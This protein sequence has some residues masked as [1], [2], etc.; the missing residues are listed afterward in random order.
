M[1]SFLLKLMNII[2][3][4]KES[5]I[6]FAI[7]DTS[8]GRCRKTKGP[9][10]GGITWDNHRVYAS[11]NRDILVYNHYLKPIGKIEDVLEK[12][13]PLIYFKQHI[14]AI[15]RDC[16]RFIDP[17]NPRPYLEAHIPT[18]NLYWETQ[19]KTTTDCAGLTSLLAVHDKVYVV[20]SKTRQLVSWDVSKNK[21]DSIEPWHHPSRELYIRRNLRGTISSKLVLGTREIEIGSGNFRGMCANKNEVAISNSVSGDLHIQTYRAGKKVTHGIV[22][23]FS[24]IT[25]MRLLGEFDFCHHNPHVLDF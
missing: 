1:R 7:Y 13:S 23:G 16:I 9:E 8:T 17:K 22:S 15:Y 2:I 12:P 3:T 20:A 18:E 25:S 5:D 19:Q 6:S 21:I 4:P 10:L 14:V 11:H 24:E